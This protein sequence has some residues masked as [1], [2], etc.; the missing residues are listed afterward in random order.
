MQQEGDV[1]GARPFN[2]DNEGGSEVGKLGEEVVVARESGATENEAAT[3]KIEKGGGGGEPVVQQG[4]F[5]EAEV[6]A[7]HLVEG[8]INGCRLQTGLDV[9]RDGSRLVRSSID[10][11][12]R[13]DASCK[14]F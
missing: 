6:S 4:G 13:G 10:G 9:G 7:L 14:S 2:R 1:R 12:S 5:K 11:K 3:I 8:H